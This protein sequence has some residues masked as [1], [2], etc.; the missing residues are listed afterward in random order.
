M[1]PLLCLDEKSFLALC[2]L[3]YVLMPTTMSGKGKAKDKV[4]VDRVSAATALNHLIVFE[5]V[6]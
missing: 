6:L 4:H 3:P 1:I 5:K 2:L